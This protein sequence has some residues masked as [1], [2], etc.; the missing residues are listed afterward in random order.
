MSW[1]TIK[2]ELEFIWENGIVD[3]KYFI[4]AKNIWEA[5][6]WDEV[7]IINVSKNPNVPNYKVIKV[8]SDIVQVVENII[9][10][11]VRLD[12]SWNWYLIIPWKKESIFIEKSNLLWA[13]TWDKVKTILWNIN[14]R[15]QA[16]VKEVLQE[17]LVFS[18]WVIIEKNGKKY[19]QVDDTK[20]EFELEKLNKKN[21]ETW[22]IV[23]IKILDSDKTE[24]EEKIA[25]IWDY[26][27]EIL[28][29]A[30]CNWLRLNFSE[31]VLNEVSKIEADVESKIENRKDLRNL[32]TIT[33]DWP[34]SK[35][36]DDAISIEELWNWK[37][38]LYVH[39]AD[40]A[41]YVG[42][43]SELDKEAVLRWNSYY[44]ADRVTPMY[45]EKLSN[46]ICSLNPHT[47]KLTITAEIVIDKDWNPI[48]EESSYYESVINT[49]FRMTYEEMDKI[50]SWELKQ[51]N[52]LLFWNRVTKKLVNQA[53]LA[54]NLSEKIWSFLQR[55]GELEINSSETKIIVDKKKQPIWIKSYP[56]YNSNDWIKNFMVIA[57][58]VIPQLVEQDLKKLWFDEF[59]FVFRTHGIPE[60]NSIIKLDN[61]LKVLWVQKDFSLWSSES[62]SK[63]LEQIKW[64]PKEKYLNKRITISLQKAIYT[65]EKEWHFGLALE[66]Y[67]HFTSPIRRYS[68]TQIHRIIKDI[69]NKRLIQEKFE[70]Y[71]SILPEIAEKCSIQEQIAT[72]NE[73]DVNS[74]LAYELFKDK[75]WEE[76]KWYV[77]DI[78]KQEVKIVLDNTVSWYLEP[79]IVENFYKEKLYDWI[80]QLVDNDT[81]KIIWL[82]DN[83]EFEVSRVDEIQQNI[84]FKIK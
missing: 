42:E 80:Y 83:L 29:I 10:W 44:Y 39:I 9:E 76:F 48:L 62:F 84:Y 34:D 11:F 40:V 13:K 25:R 22:D 75:I 4:E 7:E 74:Y 81:W 66:Y 1:E 18:T 51:K 45:P 52:E 60:P 37:T 8:I 54:S 77:D 82:W 38:K 55:N 50:N 46:N 16:L 5:K 70:H 69:L 79:E 26:W 35:D 30:A 14:W 43:G 65:A 41:E 21:F 53:K 6:P 36:L 61:T 19:L 24:I 32:F 12:N 3:D 59:P 78:K 67:S 33:I 23:K 68:D 17:S 49:N 20:K 15:K 73:R 58:N 28:E 57:N 47:D 56:K 71:K 64:D 2:W 63:L 27:V 72:Q 31:S